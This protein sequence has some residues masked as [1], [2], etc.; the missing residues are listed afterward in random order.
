MMKFYDGDSQGREP[1]LSRYFSNPI[2]LIGEVGGE[3]CGLRQSCDRSS[4]VR[5][6]FG[7]GPVADVESVLAG[8]VPRKACGNCLRPLAHGPAVC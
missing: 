3:F 1:I 2:W 7:G 8:I 6:E 5:F 4:K